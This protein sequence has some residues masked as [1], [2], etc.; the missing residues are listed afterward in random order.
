M[1]LCVAGVLT[2][3]LVARATHAQNERD[4]A[5]REDKRQ[6]SIDDAWVYDDL[7]TAMAVAEK[8]NRPLMVVFR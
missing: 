6:L 2:L 3:L 1:K 7:V 4:V 8:T 5:V